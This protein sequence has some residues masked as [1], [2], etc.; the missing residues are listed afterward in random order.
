MNW[1]VIC[2]AL[3][4]MGFS[5]YWE[6]KTRMNCKES[7]ET[8]IG[9]YNPKLILRRGDFTVE[10]WKYRKRAA[11]TIN[12]GTILIILMIFLICRK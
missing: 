12:L 7:N 6:I 4:I 2:F 5:M 10:G 1:A 11:I 8:G 9:Y 3:L